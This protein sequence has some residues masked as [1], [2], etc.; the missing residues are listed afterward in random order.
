[1]KI[2]KESTIDCLIKYKKENLQYRE[3]K[4]RFDISSK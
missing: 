3:N 2:N 4:T 1:M